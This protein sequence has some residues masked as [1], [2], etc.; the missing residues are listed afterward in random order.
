MTVEK[1]ASIGRHY[2]LI[3]HQENKVPRFLAK[4]LNLILNYHYGLPTRTVVDLDQALSELGKGLRCA[5]LIQ[6]SKIQTRTTIQTLSRQGQIP[7]FLV[8]PAASVEEH[9]DL[10][11]GMERVHLCSWE[12]AFS[13]NDTSLHHLVESCLAEDGIGNLLK[14]IDQIPHEILQL[15]L[16]RWLQNLDTLPT[17]PEIV[18]RIMTMVNDPDTAIEDLETLLISDAAIVHK[19]LQVVNSSTIAGAGRK[20]EWTLKEAIVRLGLKKVGAIAQQIKLINS[21][22]RSAESNFD[23]RRY[24][25]HSVGCALIADKLYTRKL[26]PLKGKIEFSDYWIAA[27]LHDAGKLVLGLFFWDWFDQVVRRMQ[28]TVKPFHKTEAQMGSSANHEHIGQLLMLASGIAPELAA[29]VGHHHTVGKSP[30]ELVCLLHMANN[31]CRDLG[32]GYFADERGIYSPAV[33]RQLG[34]QAEDLRKLKEALGD[35]VVGEIKEL[36]GQCI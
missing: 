3:V 1:T 32:L 2:G 8:F 5:F 10:C 14:E 19:L 12:K 18:L 22:A 29:S 7:L 35:E 36:V 28:W 4:Y 25:E 24:W 13:Q 15:R 33:L 21:F 26:L 6:D 30:A 23:L 17:L 20:A 31:L 34:F 9:Q 11:Q 27:L 16:K